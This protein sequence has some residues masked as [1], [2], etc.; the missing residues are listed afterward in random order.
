M[1][2]GIM[3]G[4]F[5]PIHN[6]HLMLANCAAEEYDLDKVVLMVAPNPPHKIPNIDVSHRIEMVRLAAAGRDKF[7]VS[8][9]E[10]ERKG[11]SY[12]VDTLRILKSRNP[13]DE[14]YLILGSDEGTYFGN[15]HLA[16]EIAD[17]ATVV[18][19]HRPGF[20][21]E[22]AD[23]VE[24]FEVPQMNLSSSEIR[25]RIGEGKTVRY[26][27]PDCVIDYIKEKGLY[28]RRNNI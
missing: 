10:T 7:E 20:D 26:L 5:D 22:L 3:G 6:A 13:E 16:H 4:T 11:P 2:I 14:F 19:A 12:T 1:K 9:L 28:A 8:T 15:W 18:C 21:G 25:K 24:S 27:L 23:R 17:M